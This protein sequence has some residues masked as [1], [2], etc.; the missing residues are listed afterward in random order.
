MPHLS[1]RS[2]LMGAAAFGGSM[3]LPMRGFAQSA[4]Q[5]TLTVG[6][7]TLDVRGRAATVYGITNQSGESG[8]VLPIGSLFDV[9]VRN[10]IAEPTVVHWH[11]LTPPFTYDGSSV[12]QPPIP[13][14]RNP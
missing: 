9:R 7:R 14:G 11:G 12:S 1:R 3:A 8:L 10:T 6:T 13:A 2:V 5:N 4:P